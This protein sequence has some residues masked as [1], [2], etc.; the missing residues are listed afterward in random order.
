L[1]RITDVYLYCALDLTDGAK[2]IPA[3]TRAAARLKVQAFADRA[4]PWLV[5]ALDAVGYDED[6]A[7]HDLWLSASGSGSGFRDHI[8]LETPPT[9][10]TFPLTDRNGKPYSPEPGATLGECL[11]A[12]AYGTHTAIA[13]GAYCDAYAS[14]GWLYLL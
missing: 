13:P 3:A 10:G 14:R 6:A 8:A 5:Q 7:G 4:G 2:R 1:D 9:A 11:D 12:A